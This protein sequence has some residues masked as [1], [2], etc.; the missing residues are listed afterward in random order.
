VVAEAFGLGID[1]AQVFKVL[2]AELKISPADVVYITGDSGSGKSVL[3]R[4]TL[5][6]EIN[7]WNGFAIACFFV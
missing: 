2:D 4:M 3:L 7:R 6:S 1:D 5:E